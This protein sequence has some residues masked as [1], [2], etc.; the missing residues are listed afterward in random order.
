MLDLTINM[1]NPENEVEFLNEIRRRVE[2][3]ENTISAPCKIVA[4]GVEIDG[5]KLTEKPSEEVIL[6]IASALMKVSKEAE[7]E[8]FMTLPSC[9]IWDEVALMLPAEGTCEVAAMYNEKC[10][11]DKQNGTYEIEEDH[12][13]CAEKFGVPS[14]KTWNR[15]A[16]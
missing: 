16:E 2:E 8:F 7:Y 15:G 9:S 11:T 3:Y 12:D 4:N 14:V 13:R 1:P 10:E 5:R 6:E